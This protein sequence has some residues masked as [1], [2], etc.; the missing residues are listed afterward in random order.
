[1]NLS[2]YN[3]WNWISLVQLMSIGGN[4]I[5]KNFDFIFPNWRRN[6][7][8]KT[9]DLRI[10]FFVVLHLQSSVRVHRNVKLFFCWVEV[11]LQNSNNNTQVTPIF[12]L[13]FFI[14]ILSNTFRYL[15]LRLSSC[16]HTQIFLKYR[17]WE[18]STEVD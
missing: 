13:L 12:F 10:F 11:T 15:R 17:K 7:T 8:K 2:I 6:A 14:F 18:L 5:N 4:N 9:N 3:M 1:M 16:C